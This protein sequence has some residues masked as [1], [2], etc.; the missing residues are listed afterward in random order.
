MEDNMKRILMIAAAAFMA[1]P[2]LA[3]AAKDAAKEPA[4][5]T[6]DLKKYVEDAAGA[7]LFEVKA[8]QL[9]LQRSQDPA[10]REFAQHMVSEHTDSTN[11]LKVEL[12]KAKLEIEPPKALDPEKQAMLDKLMNVGMEDFNKLYMTTLIAGHQEALD[13]HAA[14]AK[15]GTDSFRAFART[16]TTHT[17]DHLDQAK[18]IDGALPAK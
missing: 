2:A 18:R 9:A 14:F 15:T 1:G 16:M 8:S 7:D 6:I 5:H 17:K 11:K 3:Q 10:I 12:D 4:P 13:M